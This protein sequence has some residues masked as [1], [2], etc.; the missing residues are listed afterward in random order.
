MGNRD[1]YLSPQAALRRRE[2]EAER[3]SAAYRKLRAEILAREPPC[4]WCGVRMATEADHIRPASIG[5]RSTPD[6][7]VPSCRPCNLRR[8]RELQTMIRNRER[9]G[10]VVAPRV[11]VTRSK[12]F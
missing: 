12:R 11:Q 1:R 8:G 10:T 4:Y 3:K 6:N 7:L 9:G 5:G 2:A